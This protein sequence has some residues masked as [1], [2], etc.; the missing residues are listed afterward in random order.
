MDV[1]ELIIGIKRVADPAEFEPMYIIIRKVQVHFYRIGQV[2]NGITFMVGEAGMS[3][4]K[5]ECNEE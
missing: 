4:L 3:Q 1:G 5:N 2:V